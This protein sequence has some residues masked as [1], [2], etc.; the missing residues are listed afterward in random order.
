[1]RESVGLA[2]MLARATDS[3]ADTST[4][5]LSLR[6]STLTRMRQAISGQLSREQLGELQQSLTQDLS[7]QQSNTAERVLLQQFGA[8]LTEIE[9]SSQ[10]VAIL[11][12]KVL[13]TIIDG[14]LWDVTFFSAERTSVTRDAE[15]H[16]YTYAV[17]GCVGEFWT[18]LGLC[19][20]GEHFCDP[21][22]SD[23][24]IKAGIRYGQGLQLINILR[25]QHED[26]DRGRRYLC[27]DTAV[28]LERAARYMED[29][30]DYSR[31]LRSF[32]LRF[33]SMLP[34]LIGQKTLN[35]LQKATPNQDRVKISR[36]S[37]YGCL[38]KA[39]W[40][41]GFRRVA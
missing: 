33:A 41:S 26:A 16:Q 24:M 6:R 3:V 37:V 5:S 22:Q 4:A 28:W 11:I 9:R 30:L 21:R 12:R 31:H 1:M 7:P 32:R 2:Y 13:C 10:E 15:T 20:L 8:C 17:A 25:D 35:A 29:G 19:V 18:K 36:K 34:A 27:S 39:L 38:L 14:Q 23:I 40:I